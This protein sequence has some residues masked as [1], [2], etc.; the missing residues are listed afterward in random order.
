MASQI[1]VLEQSPPGI[2]GTTLGVFNTVGC[3]GVVFFLQVGGVLFDWIGP[4]APFTLVGMGNLLTFG[5]ALRVMKKTHETK[6]S[7]ERV[8]LSS[9]N[10]V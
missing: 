1:V 4:T 2:R 8:P 5:Y 6:S 10:R 7:D 3:I 9:L